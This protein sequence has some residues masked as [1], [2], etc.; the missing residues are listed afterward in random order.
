MRLRW[1][2]RCARTPYDEWPTDTM[3]VWCAGEP[4]MCGAC[5]GWCYWVCVNG[6]VHRVGRCSCECHKVSVPV[7]S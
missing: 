2:S 1:I 4:K 7:R 3:T 5:V 6:H